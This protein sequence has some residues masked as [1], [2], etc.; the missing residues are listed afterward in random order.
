MRADLTQARERREHVHGRRIG[1]VVVELREH[2]APCSLGDAAVQAALQRRE[3]ALDDRL[4]AL[5]QLARDVFLGAAQQERF[6][7]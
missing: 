6:Q 4:G 2:V 5:G 7:P 1:A 3:L